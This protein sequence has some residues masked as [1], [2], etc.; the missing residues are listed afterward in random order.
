MLCYVM[1]GYVILSLAKICNY[2]RLMYAIRG[3]TSGLRKFCNRLDYLKK[4]RPKTAA[5]EE[6]DLRCHLQVRYS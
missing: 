4:D 1:L 6:Y 5:K 2:P 3:I